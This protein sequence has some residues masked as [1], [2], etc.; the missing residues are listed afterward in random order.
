MSIEHR[1]FDF[2]A[3]HWDKRSQRVLLAQEIA[4]AILK[5]IPETGSLDVLDFGCG[6]GLITMQLQPLV[7][8]IT[9]VDSSNGMLEVLK[10][11]ISNLKLSNARTFQYDFTQGQSLP[12]KYDLIVSSMTFHHV[13]AIDILLQ[14]LYRLLMPGGGICIADLDAEDGRFHGDNTGVYHFGFERDRLHEIFCQA[15]FINVT[16]ETATHIVKADSQQNESSFSVF[17]LTAGK[18]AT[19]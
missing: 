2:A 4:D 16:I 8:S 3:E 9:G 15:G 7:H 14:Q 10:R 5:K 18:P 17:L 6:T 11:K 12:G 19:P 13:K 1:N